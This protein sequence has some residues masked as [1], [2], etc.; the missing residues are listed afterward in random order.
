MSVSLAFLRAINSLARPGMVWHLMWPVAV[1]V[2]LWLVITGWLFGSFQASVLVDL[3]PASTSPQV[4]DW[5]GGLGLIALM[6]V[7]MFLLLPFIYLTAGVLVGTIAVPL[8]VAKVAS[9]EYGDLKKKR[10]GSVLG[11]VINALGSVAGLSLALV[12]CLPLYLFPPLGLLVSISIAAWFNRRVYLYDAL[13]DHASADERA[14]LSRAH[15]GGLWR[16]AFATSALV[17]VPFA[18]FF[19]P[20]FAGLVFVHFCLGSLRELRSRPVVVDSFSSRV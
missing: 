12:L 19:A 2:V 4:A 18:N 16:T 15:R 9:A 3:L 1:A 6:L 10:G 8:M 7:W 20:A 11:S 13:M 5:V 17:L 14:Q